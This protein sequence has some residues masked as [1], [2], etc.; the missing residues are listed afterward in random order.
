MV[1]A[2]TAGTRDIL[3]PWSMG[4]GEHHNREGCEEASQSAQDGPPQW[5]I[6]WPRMP[7]ASRLGTPQLKLSKQI[8]S[9][10]AFSPQW[11]GQGNVCFISMLQ[12]V[13]P[14]LGKVTTLHSHR[15]RPSSGS[16]HAHSAAERACFRGDVSFGVST[17]AQRGS[18]FLSVLMVHLW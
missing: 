5:R 7:V 12:L 18:S 14:K 2:A 16:A 8:P 17:G 13:K 10:L 4:S 11:P 3:S 6:T 15:A 1:P 9:Y